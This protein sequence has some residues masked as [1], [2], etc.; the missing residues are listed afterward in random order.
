MTRSLCTSAANKRGKL[1]CTFLTVLK[2]ER[3]LKNGKTFTT[4]RK[5][6]SV[7]LRHDPLCVRMLS[8]INYVVNCLILL[9]F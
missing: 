9:A 2:I 4:N 8:G 3:N 6:T 7:I 1:A 5:I